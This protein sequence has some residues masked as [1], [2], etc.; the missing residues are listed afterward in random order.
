MEDKERQILEDLVFCAHEM[1]REGL[2][3]GSV[4]NISARIDEKTFYISSHSSYLGRVTETEFVKVNL[5]GE[6]IEESNLDPSSELWMHVEI[7]RARPDIGAIVHTHSPYASAY[8]VLK[9]PLKPV[10]P[11]ST[12]KLGEMPIVSYF[13]SGTREFAR[14]VANSLKPNINVALLERHGVVTVGK[15][16]HEALN[17]A[18]L[19]EEIA[20][21]NYLVDTLSR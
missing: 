7:Y 19:V 18:E 4:G 17:Y 3:I 6:K 21:I 9:R 12:Y 8:A 5:L 15:T 11:E 16:V 14:A 10:N 13:P 1:E 20:R 2:I